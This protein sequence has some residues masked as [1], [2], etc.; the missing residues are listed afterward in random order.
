MHQ[1]AKTMKRS[2]PSP[3]RVHNRLEELFDQLKDGLKMVDTEDLV[4][5]LEELVERVDSR[6]VARYGH[7]MCPCPSPS[8][9]HQQE[10]RSLSTSVN[11]FSYSSTSEKY[12]EAPSP[13]YSQLETHPTKEKAKKIVMNAVNGALAQARETQQ[14]RLKQEKQYETSPSTRGKPVEGGTILSRLVRQPDTIESPKPYQLPHDVRPPTGSDA[15]PFETVTAGNLQSNRMYSLRQE[16]RG[17]LTRYTNRKQ[18]DALMST[19]KYDDTD[20]GQGRDEIYYDA[21]MTDSPGRSQKGP[22]QRSS[23][24]QSDKY[25][26][27][28]SGVEKTED[29]FTTSYDKNKSALI[30]AFDL[31]REES[32]QH[33]E[34]GPIQETKSVGFKRVLPPRSFKAEEMKGGHDYG[35]EKYDFLDSK[36]PVSDSRETSQADNGQQVIGQSSDEDI[37]W[38]ARDRF[39]SGQIQIQTSTDQRDSISADYFRTATISSDNTKD[40]IVRS[41]VTGVVPSQACRDTNLI[42]TVNRTLRE[43]LPKFT[44][45]NRRA[46]GLMQV[47]G[48]ILN[49]EELEDEDLYPQYNYSVLQELRGEDDH[50]LVLTAGDASSTIGTQTSTATR[51]VSRKVNQSFASQTVDVFRD[52]LHCRCAKTTNTEAFGRSQNEIMKV[53]KDSRENIKVELTLG[54]NNEPKLAEFVSNFI[55]A[56]RRTKLAQHK[57]TGPDTCSECGRSLKCSSE[58]QGNRLTTNNNRSSTPCSPDR[59]PSPPS[60]KT[61]IE[62]FPHEID[63]AGFG[64]SRASRARKDFS[65]QDSLL[66]ISTTPSK[67]EQVPV[68]SRSSSD[69]GTHRSLSPVPDNYS[70]GYSSTHEGEEDADFKPSHFLEKNSVYNTRKSETRKTEVPVSIS[71][72]KPLTRENGEFEV[73]PGLK[74]VKFAPLGS[75]EGRKSQPPLDI[76]DIKTEEEIKVTNKGSFL[77]EICGCN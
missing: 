19:M 16:A 35:H 22:K 70:E 41:Q 11:V 75:R 67:E 4:A 72:T 34:F 61:I 38:N 49:D 37:W 46:S 6:M 71:A 17:S 45:S 48:S 28:S 33:D 25:S 31:E 52:A 20:E 7:G 40:A 3:C 2:C 66:P 32:P 73:H 15:R 23:P 50:G 5:L 36:R 30:D 14:Y 10:C 13:R 8:C 53:L 69:P 59:S 65:A 51:N 29:R 54:K 43:S 44:I 56:Q 39:S 77:G 62:T 9:K 64:N 63:H 55:E 1:Q 27:Y 68:L 18:A 42:Y 12:H 76:E 58:R 24:R 57:E 47:V 60:P 74:D 26:S 21:E